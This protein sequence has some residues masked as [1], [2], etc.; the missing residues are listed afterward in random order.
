MKYLVEMAKYS[1][2]S[3]IHLVKSL[4][5]LGRS[6]TSVSKLPQGGAD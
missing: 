6:L 3:V 4:A 2:W 1:K 5:D